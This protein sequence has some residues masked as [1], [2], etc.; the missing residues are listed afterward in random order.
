MV[1]IEFQKLIDVVVRLEIIHKIFGSKSF[2]LLWCIISVVMIIIAKVCT[3]CIG[4]RSGIRI[5]G[6]VFAPIYDWSCRQG[7]SAFWDFDGQIGHGFF[8]LLSYN[9][10]SVVSVVVKMYT[11]VL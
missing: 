11:I 6:C 4:R 8:V 5:S 1:T 3:R 2:F 7:R 9:D 10:K